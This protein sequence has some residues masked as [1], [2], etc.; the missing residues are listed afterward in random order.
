M[1]LR[2][3][4]ALIADLINPHA[5][6]LDLGCGEGAL[7]AHLQKH[8][9]V[10]GYGLDVDPANIRICLEK[11]VNVI[12]QNLDEGLTNFKTNSFNMV[13]MTETLQSV[14]APERLLSEMLRVG[15][16]C[17]ITFP[18]FGHWRCRF[19]LAM[20]GRMPVAKHIPHAWFDTP[21]IHMCTFRDFENLCRDLNYPIIERRVVNYR[22]LASPLGSLLPNLLGSVAFY[23]LGRMPT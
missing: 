22:N 9:E 20:L 23:R 12:E 14:R 10:N 18:N 5:R 13:V 7:L 8:K 16:E 4:L 2:A 21:N 15:E 19:Q 3:D 6:V 1:T 11:G 17:I